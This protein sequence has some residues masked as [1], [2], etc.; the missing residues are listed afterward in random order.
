MSLPKTSEP[1]SGQA[2]RAFPPSSRH[3]GTRTVTPY[4]FC[5]GWGGYNRSLRVGTA[6]AEVITWIYLLCKTVPNSK[7]IDTK[8]G[9]YGGGKTAWQDLPELTIAVYCPKGA[10][11]SNGRN[12]WPPNPGSGPVGRD[13]GQPGQ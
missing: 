7:E 2:R 1:E 10:P 12:S 3:R 9:A 6:K 8:H 13:F 11:Y 5:S 4:S